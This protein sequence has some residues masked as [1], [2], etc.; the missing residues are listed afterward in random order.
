MIVVEDLV[1]Y[2]RGGRY[3]VSTE[4]K[5]QVSIADWL[6]LGQVAF[7]RER[8]LAPGERIDFFVE[9]GIGIEAK[10]RCDK[11]KIWRQLERYAGIKEVTALILMTGTAMG[12][13]PA[14]N[15]KPLFYVSIGR[16]GL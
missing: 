12:L 5:L 4:A 9:S 1:R 10:T 6:A 13:P 16:A 3:V 11:R 7:E 15:G 8:R 2:L 14:V